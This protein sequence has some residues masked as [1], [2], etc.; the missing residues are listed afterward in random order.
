VNDFPVILVDGDD[1]TLVSEQL[2]KVVDALV[3]GGDRDLM[4]EDYREEGVDL[5]SVADSCATPPFLAERRVVVVR[6]AGRFLTDE[7]APLVSYLDDPLP[8]TALV[9]AAGAGQIAPKL[10]AAVKAKGHVV[11]TK[12]TQR[13]SAEWI[14]SRLRSAPV[15]LDTEAERVVREHFGED[16]S[17]LGSL[18]EVL[19][20]AYGEG[21]RVGA[22]DLDPYLGE[23]GS[24]TPW[25]FTD[26]IDNGR[27]EQAV[28]YLHRLLGAGDRHPLQV[29]AMLHR[30]VQSLLR[31]DDPSI[32]TE[33]QAAEAMGIAKGR[34]TYPAK[35]ALAAAQRWGSAGIAEAVG[36]LARADIELKGASGMPAEAVLEVLVARLCFRARSGRGSTGGRPAGRAVGRSG[37]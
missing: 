1:P 4:V 32:R 20:A 22:A 25:D 30:H 13:E 15:K 28:A 33:A 2:A 34:S 23:A 16:V 14:R 29:L 35:K 36:L 11:S 5:A 31:V 6:D 10:L 7:V 12:V 8:T 17:R 27:A 19:A 37:R 26:A 24:V 18:L 21:S 3:G 9:L